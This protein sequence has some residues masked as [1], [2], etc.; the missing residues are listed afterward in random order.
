MRQPCQDVQI[1][2]IGQWSR[3]EKDFARIYKEC[4][5]GPPYYEEYEDDWIIQNVYNKHLGHGCVAVA[6]HRGELI[7][8]SCAERM[9]DGTQSS[10]YRYLEQHRATLPFQIEK[11]CYISEVAVVEEMRRK[12]VGTDLLKVLCN[13]GMSKGLSHY[14]AR[15]AAEGSNSMGIFQNRLHANILDGEQSVEAFDGEVVT[16]SKKRV[17]IW[18]TLDAYL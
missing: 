4:F 6:L 1:Y 8:L 7:G 9:I 13:W 5:G 17:Y 15:T 14:T 10:P 12:G 3:M 2:L 11:T 16:A 18:G